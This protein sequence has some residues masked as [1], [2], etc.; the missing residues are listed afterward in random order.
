MR[1]G[2]GMNADHTLEEVGQQFSLTRE[3]IRQIG[4]RALRKLKHPNRSTVPQQLICMLPRGLRSKNR[5]G[6]LPKGLANPS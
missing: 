3:R 2:I 4:A 1:F 5:I 6:L